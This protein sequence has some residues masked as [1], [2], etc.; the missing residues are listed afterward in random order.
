MFID[1]GFDSLNSVSDLAAG[2]YDARCKTYRG[3]DPPEA[4]F[5]FEYTK[6]ASGELSAV[7]L[8]FVEVDGSIRVRDFVRLPDLQWRDSAGER[9]EALHLLLPDRLAL[10]QFEA[11]RKWA[12]QT[13][14]G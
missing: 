8:V 13:V 2:S 1:I 3:S 11:V 10:L 7:D 9:A 14:S 4:A 6:S 12:L 5:L